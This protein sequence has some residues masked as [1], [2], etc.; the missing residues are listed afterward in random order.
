M[1]KC[2]PKADLGRYIEMR[3]ARAGVEGGGRMGISATG[4]PAISMAKLRGALA[5]VVILGGAAF[6]LYG[7]PVTPAFRGAAMTE[8]NE[9][10]GGSY[11]SFDLDWVVGLRPRWSCGD[12]SEPAAA[13]TDMGWWVTPAW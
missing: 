9:M 12:R 2:R 4:A 13:R 10:T 6:Y 11:R 5:S 7:P 1:P 3:A 8:C